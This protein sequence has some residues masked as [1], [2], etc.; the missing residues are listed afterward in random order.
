MAGRGRQRTS[1]GKRERE[2][3]R[4]GEASGQACSPTTQQWA[5]VRESC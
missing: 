2:R 1:F 4:P 3:K 5:A